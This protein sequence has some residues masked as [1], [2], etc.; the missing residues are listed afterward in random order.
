VLDAVE[1]SQ[2]AMGGERI[3]T[4]FCPA[5]VVP[6]EILNALADAEVGRAVGSEVE[7]VA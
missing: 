7:R 6:A 4:A 2:W 5:H 1:A 3:T